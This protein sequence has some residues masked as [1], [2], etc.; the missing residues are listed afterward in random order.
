MDFDDDDFDLDLPDLD[1]QLEPAV[2]D[3]EDD[4]DGDGAG[5][6]VPI[7]QERHNF[8]FVQSRQKNTRL[9]VEGDYAYR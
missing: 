6:A 8:R 4:F 1:A 2:Q 7:A 3:L 5:D 9:L